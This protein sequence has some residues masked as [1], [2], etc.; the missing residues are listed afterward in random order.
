MTTSAVAPTFWDS[1]NFNLKNVTAMVASWHLTGAT[2]PEGRSGTLSCNP[3]LDAPRQLDKTADSHLPLEDRAGF[4]D[5]VPADL[6]T[7]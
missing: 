7:R 5:N 4:H 2:L 6:L 1:D 3:A